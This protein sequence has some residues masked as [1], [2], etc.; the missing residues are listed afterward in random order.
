M[1]L[2]AHEQ[3]FS[4]IFILQ[5]EYSGSNEQ[6]TTKSFKNCHCP[7]RPTTEKENKSEFKRSFQNKK[8]NPVFWSQPDLL[9]L[10]YLCPYLS[11]PLPLSSFSPLEVTFLKELYP[12]KRLKSVSLENIILDRKKS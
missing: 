4:L 9:G 10:L 8:P 5:S 3:P 2:S 6:A 1:F 12:N 7:W 11:K